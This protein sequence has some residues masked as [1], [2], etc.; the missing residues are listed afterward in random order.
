[1]VVAEAVIRYVLDTHALLWYLQNDPE[2]GAGAQ[3]AMKLAE[4]G[5]AQLL[6]PSI[7]LAELVCLCQELRI[8]LSLDSLR[9][10]IA[11]V[12][13]VMVLEM[14][15]RQLLTFEKLDRSLEMHDRLIL[16]DALLAG[17]TLVPRD[18]RLQDAGVVPTIW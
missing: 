12:S 4:R 6:I 7:V 13:N 17:A 9:Q 8:R 14:G 2:L 5:D 18:R 1:M 16:A 15:L 11:S 10:T 3:A